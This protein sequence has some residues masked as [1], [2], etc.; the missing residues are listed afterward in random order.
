[1][2]NIGLYGGSF[3][4]I[5]NGHVNAAI[6]MYELL[7]LDELIVMPAKQSPHKSTGPNV[8]DHH[9]Y[10]MLQIAFNDV[11]STM[12]IEISSFEL[13]QQSKS[14]TFKTIEH[15]KMIYPKERL[16]ML[17]GEDQLYDFDQWKNVQMIIEN[18]YVVIVERYKD[19]KKLD[20]YISEHELFKHYEARFIPIDIQ[21]TEMSSTD[22]RDKL[23]HH[24][25]VRHMLPKSVYDYI[26]EEHLYERKES[27]SINS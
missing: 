18:V 15:L 5:H 3:D 23:A 17:I 19:S 7:S 4:P 16:Y 21:I 20:D 6:Q 14:Y 22:I 10:E 25:S 9:R 24:V 26:K 1:M 11:S 8:E 2:A 13:E 12:N 27:D